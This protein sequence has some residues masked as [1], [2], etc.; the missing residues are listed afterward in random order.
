[1]TN[2]TMFQPLFIGTLFLTYSISAYD[3]AVEQQR[4]D[5]NEAKWD[6]Y[7]GDGGYVMTL[8]NNCYCPPEWRG[9]FQ[10][11]VNST[12]DAISAVYVEGSQADLLGTSASSNRLRG[13]I[14]ID[15]AFDKIQQ[16]LDQ[17]AYDLEVTYDM[18]A[19]YPTA[20]SIDWD[21]MIADEETNLRIENVTLV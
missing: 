8:T 1:M 12:G 17:D 9:P 3:P 14:T 6:S 21:V 18:T 7:S 16:A 13:M 4:L 5:D 10:V 2:S 19:G 15:S 20:I 11:T